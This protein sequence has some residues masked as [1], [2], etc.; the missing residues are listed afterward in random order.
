M[1]SD[2]VDNHGFTFSSFD[3]L[4]A[5]AMHRQLCRSELAFS[6]KNYHFND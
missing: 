3:E 4:D 1:A 6:V 2:P 5:T